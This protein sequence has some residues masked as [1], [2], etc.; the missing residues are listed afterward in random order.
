M[1]GW[2]AI[3]CLF[4]ELPAAAPL[5]EE[6]EERVRRLLYRSGIRFPREAPGGPVYTTQL[7]IEALRRSLRS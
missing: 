1:V 4:L 5:S 6:E 2:K 3:V 7:T